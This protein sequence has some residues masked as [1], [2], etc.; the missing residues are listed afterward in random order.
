MCYIVWD[1]SHGNPERCFV[2][3]LDLVGSMFNTHRF[4]HVSSSTTSSNIA[5]YLSHVRSELFRQSL[6]PSHLEVYKYSYSLPTTVEPDTNPWSAFAEN[7]VDPSRDR[8]AECGSRR[9]GDLGRT[10]KDEPRMH[11]E[12]LGRAQVKHPMLAGRWPG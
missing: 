1:G 6:T 10:G 5:I 12:R 2:C 8:A 7:M 11:L 4:K 3:V 9:D